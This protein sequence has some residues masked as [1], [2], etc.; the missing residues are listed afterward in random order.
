MLCA[1]IDIGT[2]T[3]HL[4]IASHSSIEPIEIVYKETIPVKL[5]EDSFPKGK[6]KPAAFVR[7]LKALERFKENIDKYD[8]SVI[9]AV[10]TE[11]LRKA[12]DA[13]VFIDEV[14]KNTGIRIEVIS[15]HEEADLI[16]FSIKHLIPNEDNVLVM[17]IGGG[18]TE[19]IIANDKNVLWKDSFPLGST[20]LKNRFHD[21][22]PIT[23]Q[24]KDKLIS[25]LNEKLSI[26]FKKTAKYKPCSLIGTSGSFE[27]ICDLIYQNRGDYWTLTFIDMEAFKKLYNELLKSTSQERKKMP[28]M[29]TLREPLMVVAT[30]LIGV[31]INRVNIK[32]LNLAQT[33]L[34]EGLALRT[35]SEYN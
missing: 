33:A 24:N 12:G 8:V 31:V 35:L 22:D 21:F 17:D 1:I 29:S 5:G 11:S 34:K 6:I 4:L 18:S 32:S 13:K 7:G 20:I 10:A 30:I 28:G 23:K 2:N 19:F 14:Y 15:G 16:Y 27:T 3:F 26:L 25:Q 9:K